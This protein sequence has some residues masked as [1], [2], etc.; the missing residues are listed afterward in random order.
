[1]AHIGEELGLV[2]AG[3]LELP[4]LFLNLAEQLGVLD[5]EH[6][7]RRERLHE[8]YDLLVEFTWL[9]APDDQRADDLVRPQQRNNQDAAISGVETIF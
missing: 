6:R 7:L 3:C 4:A 2:A 8:V 1:M 9:A 5:G